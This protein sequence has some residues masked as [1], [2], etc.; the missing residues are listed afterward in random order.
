[1]KSEKHMGIPKAKHDPVLAAERTKTKSEKNTR[2]WCKGVEGREHKSTIVKRGWLSDRPCD[3]TNWWG[4]HHQ[5]ICDECKKVLNW[6]MGDTCPER[7]S[8]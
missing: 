7:V 5:E 2:R 8:S 3:L 1:M 4:C 6:S